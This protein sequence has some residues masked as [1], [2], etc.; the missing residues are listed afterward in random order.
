VARRELI[1]LIRSKQVR[2]F[3]G[4]GAVAFS[5]EYALFAL[6]HHW[7]WRAGAAQALSFLFAL[8]ISFT[9]NRTWA[10]RTRQAPLHG[11]RI[12]FIQ[13]AGLA[14]FNLVL[15]T[16]VISLMVEHKVP[17]LLAKVLIM[18]M[19]SCWNFLLYRTVIFKSNASTSA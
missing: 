7:Q 9:M 15:T 2:R 17:A 4:V 12:Q 11:Q 1:H 18:G 10:F 16:I 8:V 14:L 3:L 6:L 19:V 13:Y 5:A